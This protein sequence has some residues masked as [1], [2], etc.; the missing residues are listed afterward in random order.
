M[1]DPWLVAAALA[2]L[3]VG[4]VLVLALRPDRS[5]ELA[6]ATARADA[7]QADLAA[8]RE[9]RATDRQQLIAQQNHLGALTARL[10]QAEADI[11]A[12]EDSFRQLAADA[13]TTAAQRLVA[14]SREGLDPILA[15]MREQLAQF[16]A[17]IDQVYEAEARERI[18]LGAEIAATLK[19]SQQVGTQADALARALSAQSQVRGHLGEVMLEQVL[20]AAGLE[21]E[22]HYVVQGKGLD[23][24]AE[25]GSRQRPDVIVTLPDGKALIIDSKVALVDYLAFHQAGDAPARERSLAAFRAAVHRHAADLA[26][27]HYPAAVKARTTDFVLM[28]MPFEAALSLAMQADADLFASA[29]DKGIAIVGPNTLMMAMRVVAQTWATEKSRRSVTEVLETAAK[30]HQ[31]LAEA[32]DGFVASRAAI[33]RALAAHDDGVARLFSMRGSVRAHAEKLQRLGVRTRRALAQPHDAD[34]A[35]ADEPDEGEDTPPA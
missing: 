32:N 11:A 24:R 19:V 22:L 34:T 9:G 6:V 30:L 4:A 35:E 1:P 27:K 15:P 13:V 20:Q 3:V 21:P 2:G 25:D 7:M 26:R 8:E 28:F 17:R 33:E 12:R 23:I 10:A 5:A 14:Q 29:W 31:Q 18:R 16:R